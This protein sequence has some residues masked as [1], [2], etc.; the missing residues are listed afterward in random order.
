MNHEREHGE[1]RRVALTVVAA[2]PGEFSTG[3]DDVIEECP[4]SFSSLLLKEDPQL[5]VKT[6]GTVL[7]HGM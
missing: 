6:M 4:R 5:Q 3:T 7:T 1:E 2:Q